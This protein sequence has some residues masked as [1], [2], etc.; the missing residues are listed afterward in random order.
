MNLSIILRK[1]WQ[2]LWSYRALWLFGAILALVGRTAIYTGPWLDRDNDN[3]WT[4][5][6]LSEHITVRVPGVDMTIDLT[7]PER[8]RVV[9]PNAT[10]WREF[11]DLVD[12]LNLGTSIQLWPILIE[13]LVIL[14]LSILLGTIARYVSETA[15]IRMV[16]DTEESS[17]RLRVGEGMRRGWSLRAWRLFLLDLT[18]G[19]LTALATIV[20]F[21]LAVTPVLLAIGRGD[22][23]IVISGI[24]TVG[25]LGLAVFLWL[26]VGIVLSVLLQPIRRAWVLEDQGLLASIQQGAWM[27]THHLKDIGP[28]WLIWMGIRL[29][30]VP[31]GMVILVVLIPVVV[32]TTLIGVAAGGVPGILVTGMAIPFTSPITAWIMG[33]MA[34]LPFFILVMISPLLFVNGLVETYLSSVWTLAYR[35]L[36][37][38]E[39]SIPV[40]LSPRPLT[41]VPGTTD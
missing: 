6:I 17:R 23:L 24:G 22:I 36:K 37:A 7:N 12:E 20:V 27:T 30:W 35:Q 34:G 31:V 14:F 4:K 15:L 3:E 25:L 19:I 18:I 10:L 16:N 38:L 26:V 5:I 33:L 21:G 41:P 29:L 32:L 11:Q 1:S 2:L 8:L 40:P 9:N 39:H 13:F 28:L